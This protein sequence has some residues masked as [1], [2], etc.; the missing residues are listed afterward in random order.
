MAKKETAS[1]S[2]TEEFSK[3]SKPLPMGIKILIG[4]VGLL[5]ILGI[6]M[7]TLGTV[8]FSKFGLNFM[9]K[10]VETKTGVRLDAEGKTMTIKDSKTGAEINVGEGKIPTGFPKDFPLYPGAKVEG[11]ISGVENQ[12]GKGFWLI[13]TTADTSEKVSAFYETNL[14][15]S[16][17]IVGST[18]N[19]GP[20][21]TW[22]V[23]KGDTGGT[24]MV[25]ADD[26]TKGTSIVIT[27]APKEKTTPTEP[28][29]EE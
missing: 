1:T 9:K 25:A 11:N 29:P 12:A 22:E 13:M 27:L 2:N 19:I 14:P 15:K 23:I 21:S 4:C 7:G 26:K 16:G 6:I 24:V 5:V 17:W 10:A 18:M 8:I 3:K 20:S 28:I